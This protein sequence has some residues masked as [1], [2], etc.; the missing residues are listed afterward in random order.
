MADLKEIEAHIAA[1]FGPVRANG[2][3]EAPTHVYAVVDAS[4]QPMMIPAALDAMASRNSCLYSGEALREFGDNAAWVA[5]LLPTESTLGWL[6]E[7][8]FG[9]RWMIFATS[10]L[11][12]AAFIRHLKKFTMASNDDG[13]TVF[14]R[15][16]DPQ[17][18]RQYLA[19]LNDRQKASFF[20]GVEHIM[21]E[22]SREKG[23]ILS[24]APSKDGSLIESRIS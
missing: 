8:G 5:E 18:L 16:Y 20:E 15:F 10:K 19:V 4:R 12:L 7:Q 6:L 1:Y 11:E 13:R 22:D 9:K 17:V 2:G 23:A 3:I 24:Y 21:L 14:F